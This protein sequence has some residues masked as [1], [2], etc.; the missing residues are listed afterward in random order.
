MTAAGAAFTAG[1]AA[2]ES[3]WSRRG[4]SS[5]SGACIDP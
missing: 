5:T 2:S 4:A 1:L 3:A